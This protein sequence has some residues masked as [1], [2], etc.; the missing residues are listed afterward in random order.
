MVRS[1]RYGIVRN[2]FANIER[3]LGG[4]FA[5]VATDVQLVD[6]EPIALELKLARKFEPS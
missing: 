2:A 1:R 6:A 5:D 4:E 3:T